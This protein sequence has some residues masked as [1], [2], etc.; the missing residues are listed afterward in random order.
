MFP[1][2]FLTLLS[3]RSQICVV[4]EPVI[5]KDCRKKKGKN[6]IK[7]NQRLS[8]SYNESSGKKRKWKSVTNYHVKSSVVANNMFK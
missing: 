4:G 2:L 3:G 6:K 7:L 5:F 8:V 1:Y